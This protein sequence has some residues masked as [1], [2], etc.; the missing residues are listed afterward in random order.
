MKHFLMAIGL[1]CCSPAM[2][3]SVD[4]MIKVSGQDPKGDYISVKNDSDQ[5]IFVKT[6]LSELLANNEERIFSR[7][8]LMGWTVTLDPSLFI[9]DP[10]ETRAVRLTPLTAPE[11]RLRDEVYGVAFI[12]QASMT[13][14]AS[15]EQLN[16]QVGF[17]SYYIVPAKESKMDYDLNYDR[18]SGELTLV[19]RGNT[20]LLAELDQCTKDHQASPDK[21]C[22]TTFLAI[23]GRTKKY[24][25]PAWLRKEKMNFTVLNHDKTLRDAVTR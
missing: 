2:A 15:N 5:P 7:D 12:P 6:E 4:S 18:K 25:V 8:N 10:G 9:L 24:I 3:L 16:I 14:Q 19:N 17:K 11:S 13:Q 20:L 21:P 22:S 1:L 23:V